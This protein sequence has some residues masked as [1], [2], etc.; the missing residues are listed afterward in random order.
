LQIKRRK[1]DLHASKVIVRFSLIIVV[2][3]VLQIILIGGVVQTNQF[4]FVPVCCYWIA[5]AFLIPKS[6]NKRLDSQSL[7]AVGMLAL[8]L[9]FSVLVKQNFRDPFDI[10]LPQVV[11]VRFKENPEVGCGRYET[12]PSWRIAL[13]NARE[14]CKTIAPDDSITVAQKR[15]DVR[16]GLWFDASMV[17]KCKFIVEN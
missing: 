4:L 5:I 2:T 3:F 16:S 6:F 14:N 12:N 8:I 1:L 9:V 7:I 13:I 11:C 17:V 10:K 15:R